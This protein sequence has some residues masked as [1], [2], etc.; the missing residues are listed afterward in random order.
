MADSAL[1][2]ITVLEFGNLVTA[3]YCTKLLAELGA[4]V[5]KIETPGLGDESRRRGPF[6]GDRPGVE[7]SGL[8]AYLNTSKRGITLNPGTAAGKKIFKDLIKQVDI[9]VENNAPSLM[10]ELGLTYKEIEAINPSLIMTSITPYGQTGPYRDYKAHELTLYQGTG[11]GIQSTVRY[12]GAMRPPITAAGKQSQFSAAQVG[13][14]ATMFALI[15]RD[16]DGTGQHVDIS[17]QEV[18]AGHY[19]SYIEYWTFMATET[20]PSMIP[21]VAP[22]SALQCSDGW[23]FLMAIEDH[24][25]NNLVKVMDNPD[26]ARDERFKD[27]FI[28]AANLDA[29]VPHIAAWTIQHTKE[30]VFR[31]A[32]EAHVP[33]APAYNV[34]EVVNSPQ[35][36]ANHFFVEIDHPVIGPARYPGAPYTLSET[37]WRIQR[38]A[39]L[40]GEHNEEIYCGRLGLDK[41]DLIRLAQAGIV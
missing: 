14:V 6:A 35:V 8:F 20:G 22:V 31:L 19:E 1:S 34:E 3:P 39:P 18:M 17:N 23:V 36:Q 32:Q 25:F 27:R 33:L 30:E 15:A 26:W 21:R 16:Q 40:L 2:D 4:D 13:A 11:Y 24:Q 41:Q 37:P 5:I 9:L 28:R 29:L 38:R 7:R 12:G 10:E